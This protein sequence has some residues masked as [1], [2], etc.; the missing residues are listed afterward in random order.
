[1]DVENR[2]HNTIERERIFGSLPS[3]IRES[4][5]ILIQ[6]GV[7]A[8]SIRVTE[9]FFFILHTHGQQMSKQQLLHRVIRMR[10]WELRNT[11]AGGCFGRPEKPVCGHPG[12][13]SG[14]NHWQ[15]NVTNCAW[16]SGKPLCEPLCEPMCEP[17]C[18]PT[19]REKFRHHTEALCTTFSLRSVK[20]YASPAKVCQFI[21]ILQYDH[22]FPY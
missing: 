6:V 13:M 9:N 3:G 10:W 16:A 8:L 15:D 1:M 2:T 12:T 20:I 19:W 11:V 5:S 22:V 7:Y 17:M 4:D 21:E 14:C 18:E